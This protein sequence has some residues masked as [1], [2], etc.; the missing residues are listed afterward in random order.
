MKLE[1]SKKEES[2]LKKYEK[3]HKCK[4]HEVQDKKFS[5]EIESCGMG[6]IVYVHCWNCDSYRDITDYSCW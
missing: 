4:N 2:A 3:N 6:L 1:L 5:L